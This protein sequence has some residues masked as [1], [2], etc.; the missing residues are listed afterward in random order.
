M[1]SKSNA[2]VVLL[3]FGAT[4]VWPRALPAA[5]AALPDDAYGRVVS[6]RAAKIVATLGIDDPARADRVRDVIASQYRNLRDIQAARDARLAEADAS[7]APDREAAAA[8]VRA[9][10]D[11]QV[12]R[13]HFAFVARLSAELTP[14]QVDQVKD[15]LTY[16]V[17]PGTYK[18]YLE[19]YPQLTGEQKLQ[20]SA[21][22]IEAREYAMDGGSAEEKH[23]W[24]GKYKG[25]INNYLSAAGYDAKAAE[26]AWM[27]RTKAAKENSTANAPE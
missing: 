26:Q 2:L 3:A 21:W 25:R 8:R 16:G 9:D 6:G 13:L 10:S 23:G 17:L 14:T 20:I 27:E 18:H 12:F 5:D 1:K 24:F 22:L 15:G 7:S 19:L 11:L 4:L